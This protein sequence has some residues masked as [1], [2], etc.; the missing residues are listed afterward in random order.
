MTRS[1]QLVPT[2]VSYQAG[3][4]DPSGAVLRIDSWNRTTLVSI[5]AV[6][7]VFASGRFQVPSKDRMSRSTMAFPTSSVARPGKGAGTLRL[8]PGRATVGQ[9]P[10]LLQPFARGQAVMQV[11]PH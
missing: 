10:S 7:A 5:R 1:Y 8:D 11:T 4:R 3:C 9:S 6:T 2:P